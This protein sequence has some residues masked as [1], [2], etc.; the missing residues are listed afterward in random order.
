MRHSRLMLV[1]L[2]ASLPA[3]AGAADVGVSINIGEPGFFGQINIGNAPRPEVIYPEPVYAEPVP[4]GM[5]VEPLYLR[6]PPGHEKHWAKYCREYHACNRPVYFVR[7]DWYQRAYP[8]HE[9]MEGE[10]HERHEEADR[11]E[12]HD[13]RERD[14]RDN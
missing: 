9:R 10:R 7:E 13:E 2:L 5:R 4:P 3:V 14:H 6:V 8:R 1:A 12:R 11:R